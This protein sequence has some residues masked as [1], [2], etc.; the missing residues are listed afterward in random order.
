MR[1]ALITSLEQSVPPV[2]YGGTERVV[3]ELADGLV[4][5]G[6]DV[7]L[8]ASGDSKT[9]AT[10][11]PVI[12][13]A[14]RTMYDN[15]TIDAWREY[16]KYE[17]I[18]QSLLKIKSIKPDIVHNHLAWRF[19]LFEQSIPHLM[20]STMH[21][22]LAIERERKT[23]TDHA[24]HA[25]V[26]ISNNQ[27]RTIPDLNWIATVYNGI[28]VERFTP[29]FE[30]TK[31]YFAFVGRTSP[32]KGL[33]EIVQLIL[34]SPYRLKIA[35]KVDSVD[36]GYFKERV[37]PFVDGK[38]IEFLGE[39]GHE[40]KNE[41]LQGAKALLLWLNWEEPFGLVVPEANACGT[42]VIVNKRGSMPELIEEGRTGFLVKTQKEMLNRLSEVQTLNRRACRE[43]VEKHFSVTAMVD[44][45][46]RVYKQLARQ[47]G[48]KAS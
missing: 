18:A 27:R 48:R 3:A 12:P 14:I 2:K 9:K 13:R 31:D 29:S 38:K 47:K 8:L 6:H 24:D 46:E 17:G 32:E 45:Y 43:R 19:I 5:R 42:P 33:A 11:V 37:E 7:Y 28:E 34:K 30:G 35:A 10:L 26:S 20:V 40:Q 41:L 22:P 16:W 21:G 25:F 4:E 1:I 23:Y 15:R 36:E 44:G 39:V